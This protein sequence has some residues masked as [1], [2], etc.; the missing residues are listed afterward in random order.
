MSEN[1]AANA[2]GP[3]GPAEA[4]TLF[5][6]G[7]DAHHLRA[8]LN[9]IPQMVW[10]TRPDGHVDF[11]NYRWYE[12]TGVPLGVTDGE[13]WN[14]VVHPDD[15]GR[16]LAAWR[17]AVET[18]EAYDIEYQLRHHSGTYRWTLARGLPIRDDHGAITRWFGTCTDI[19]ALKH[20]EEARA[21]VSEELSHRIKNVFSVL[22][23]IIT[24][25]G[26]IYPEAAPFVDSLLRQI[27]A[28]A[29][30]NDYVRP[31]VGAEERRKDGTLHGLI[32]ALVAPYQ[33]QAPGRILV[34][35]A[36]V[37][38]GPN[39]ATALALVLHEL[40]T[41]AVKY[42]ALSVAEGQVTIQIVRH[43]GALALVWQETGGPALATPPVGSGFGTEMAQR[44]AELQLRA[45]ITKEWAPAGLIVRLAMPDSALDG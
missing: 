30:A 2:T 8:I 42:G 26:R 4:S 14:A 20:A 18:G 22:A 38:V 40:A 24:L 3:T 34:S 17:H 13:E 35:G 41:N 25:S 5:D 11:Y 9:T 27:G 19:D 1:A 44:A 36:D 32:A 28:L 15:R 6:Q 45:T 12:F 37:S 33:D 31:S 23:S 10:S 43:H 39:G 16:A 21:L 29:R 7:L